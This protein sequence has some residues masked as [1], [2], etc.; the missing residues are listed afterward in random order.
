MLTALVVQLRIRNTMIIN[1][2]LRRILK[3]L[4][5][6]YFKVITQNPVNLREN[7]VN[8]VSGPEMLTLE[9]IIEVII[10]RRQCS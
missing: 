9:Y 10:I 4:V 3:E 8:I 6:D 1:Y 2:V 5:A 7:V